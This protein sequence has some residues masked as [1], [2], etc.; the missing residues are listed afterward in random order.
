MNNLNLVDK[1]REKA[2]IS[3]E[4]AKNALENNNW[5]ILDA[6]LYLEGQGRAKKPSISIFYTNEDKEEFINKG[7]LVNIKEEKYRNNSK[8]NFE[9]IFEEVC[10][11]IDT[12]N[13]IFF[14]IRR[15]DRVLLKLPLTVLVLLLLF[16]FWII[17]PLIVVGLFFEIEFLVS[18][19]KV[20][21]DKVN[22]V[23]SEISKN[24]LIIKEKFKKGFN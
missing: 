19:K 23:F 15:K 7:E 9:G 11:V 17:I 18:A 8:N 14:E 16:V 21:T 12:C 10:R 22:K 3:Y 1:L 20:N 24:V 6:M 13:N 5:D 2:N 4:E